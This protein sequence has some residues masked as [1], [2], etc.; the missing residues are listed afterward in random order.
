MQGLELHPS[1]D[2]REVLSRLRDRGV[3]VSLGGERVLR[4]VP[5]LTITREELD[6]GVDAVEAVLQDPPR[7]R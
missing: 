6:R 4:F 3:L 2:P 1:V 7:A 5:A